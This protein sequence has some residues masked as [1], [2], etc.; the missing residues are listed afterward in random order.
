M[1]STQRI[2]IASFNSGD[3]NTFKTLFNQYYKVLCSYVYAFIKN[4]DSTEDLVQN[5]FIS[6]WEK[7]ADFDCQEKII[8]FL[9]T[10]ARNACLNLIQHE[11]IK[12]EKL[13]KLLDQQTPYEEDS[14]LLINEFDSKLASWLKTLSPE[15]RKI[16]ELSI[17]GKKNQEIAELLNLSINTVK[18]QKVKGFKILR[19][20]YKDEYG[21]FLLYLSYASL[22]K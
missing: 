5:I 21:M 18:N 6:L 10:S 2:N 3:T 4:P 7:R 1:T 14:L 20:L 17:A 16:I 9:F 15:C 19:S 22:F 11:K 13:Q 12:K 8:S